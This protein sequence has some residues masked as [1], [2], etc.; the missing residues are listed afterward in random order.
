MPRSAGKNEDRMPLAQAIKVVLDLAKNWASLV[1]HAAEAP[2]SSAS[3]RKI[4]QTQEIALATVEK[5]LFEKPK[6]QTTTAR[7]QTRHT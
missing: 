3:L 4:A 2:E 5:H 6:T 7:R 1:R